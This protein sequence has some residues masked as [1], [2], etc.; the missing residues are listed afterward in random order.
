M[1][2]HLGGLTKVDKEL[3]TIFSSLQ[4]LQLFPTVKGLVFGAYGLWRSDS[5]NVI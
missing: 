3:L 5:V 4:A 1:V 2:N